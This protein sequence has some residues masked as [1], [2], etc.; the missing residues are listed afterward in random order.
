MTKPENSTP[1]S[2][3]DELLA[4][5]TLLSRQ[6]GADKEEEK[7]LR[8]RKRFHTFVPKL[9]GPI[10][11]ILAVTLI[12]SAFFAVALP[13]VALALLGIALLACLISSI[14]CG[15]KA[16]RMSKELDDLSR[17]INE[18]QLELKKIGTE[19]GGL[20]T[21]QEDRHDKQKADSLD[22]PQAESALDVFTTP[23]GPPPQQTGTPPSEKCPSLTAADDENNN[24]DVASSSPPKHENR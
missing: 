4:Q 24:S 20:T 6:L 17:K 1:S 22:H 5:H 3:L 12:T 18:N 21:S 13:P 14:V 7:K 15:I 8:P 23:A 16:Y 10:G 11:F 2:R 9:A 19:Y